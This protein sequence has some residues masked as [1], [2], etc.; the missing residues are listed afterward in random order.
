VR[1]WQDHLSIDAKGFAQ[2]F[3]KILARGIYMPPSSVDAA[4]VSAAHSEADIEETV[5]IMSEQL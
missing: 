3:H 1:N 4:C 5:K 2:F